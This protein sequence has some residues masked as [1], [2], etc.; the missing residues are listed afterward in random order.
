[1][2]TTKLLLTTGDRIEVDGTVD[3]AI[4]EL[5]NAARSSHGTLARMTESGTGEPVAINAEQVVSVGPG[6]E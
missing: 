5:E 2:A 6:D 4:K 1:M 3:E